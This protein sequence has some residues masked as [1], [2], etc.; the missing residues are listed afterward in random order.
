MQPEPLVLVGGGGM[1]HCILDVVDAINY[2]YGTAGRQ[3]FAVV[4]VLADPEPDVNALKARGVDY[5]GPVA[6]LV[7]L[8]SEVGY[9]IG[10]GDSKARMRIDDEARVQGRRSPV[11]VH[12]N[13][14]LGFDVEIDSGSV[15]CSHV[16]IENRVTIGRHVHVNQ[17]STIGHQSKLDD[18]TTISPMVAISGNVTT[19]QA[20]FIGTHAAV[21]EKIWI[22]AGATVGMGAAVVQDVRAE[23]TVVGVPARPQAAS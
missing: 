18:W 5:L 12:P 20:V 23:S 13:A 4:G 2:E 9:V 22:G 6:L 7:D 10:I 15:I 11:L 19:G 21:R 17:N 16:S 8:P 1:G 14:H 3:R